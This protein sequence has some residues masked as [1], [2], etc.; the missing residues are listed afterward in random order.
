MS[1]I[2][3]TKDGL[4]EKSSGRKIESPLDF[5][6]FT[7]SQCEIIQEL[8]RTFD[9]LGAERGVFAALHSWGDTMPDSE[10]LQM[11]KDLND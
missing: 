3:E 11:L 2:I 8:S 7:P 1:N 9:R 4:V 5:T 6:K 10:V